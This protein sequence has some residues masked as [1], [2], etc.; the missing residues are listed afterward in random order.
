MRDQ[1]RKKPDQRPQLP[2]HND[3]DDCGCNE[4]DT[5][6]QKAI[7]TERKVY[8][9][10]LDTAASAVY[11]WEENYLGWKDLKKKKKCLF[12]WTEKNYQAVRNLQITKGNAL[13]QFNEGIKTN[14]AVF[15][16]ANKSLSDGL[17][18]IVKKLKGV[19]TTVDALRSAACDLK[20]CVHED[21]NCTQW[22]ILTN[23]W[24]NCKGPRPEI[25]LPAECQ[26][27]EDK[28]KKLFCIPE[29]LY[30]DAEYTLKASADVAGIQ[31]FS[32]IGSL[33]SLQKSL[34][35][36]AAKLDKYL[37]DTVKKDQDDLKKVTDDF[38][39]TVQEFAKSKNIV[40]N[41]RTEFEGLLDST[42]FF[43]CPKCGCV[44]KDSDCCKPRLQ[45]CKEKICDIC[46]EVKDTFSNGSEPD[47]DAT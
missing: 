26:D 1:Y 45:D 32:N 42:G 37:Q 14:T 19:Q 43:C 18:D 39:K 3:D 41:K 31:V 40:Y 33:E 34:S 5:A 12:I 10:E 36:S 17:K 25:A 23:N 13:S 9:N 30:K 4:K 27:I 6:T 11:Q 47:N 35:D 38:A 7:N 29:A 28:F 8:C 15:L 21:C 44:S 2:P 20:H 22:G 16:K 46:D 24:G